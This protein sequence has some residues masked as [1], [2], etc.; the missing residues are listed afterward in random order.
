MT[1][2]LDDYRWLTSDAAQPW[3][4][5]AAESLAAGQSLTR[6]TA[7][8]RRD[9]SPMQTHLVLE[10]V[11]L[12]QRARDK[13]ARAG[14]MF[15]TPLGL[16]QATDEP[17]ARHKAQ[18]F[19]EDGC[20]ADLCC[21]IGGDLVALAERGWCQGIDRDPVAVHLASVNGAVCGLTKVT[22]SCRDAA[23]EAIQGCSA[24]HVDPDRRPAGRRTV[25]AERFDPSWETVEGLLACCAH[26]A[27]KVAPATELAADVARRCERQWI[28]TRGECRQQVAWFGDLAHH[29]GQCSATIVVG[30]RG[31]ATVTGALDEIPPAADEIGPF[32]Y[33]PSAAV[34]AAR[35]T[36]ALCRQTGLAALD[37]GRSYL[38]ADEP[39]DHPLVSGF[40]VLEAL[41]FDL[42]RLAAALRSHDVA[43]SEIKKRG[44]EID[45]AELRRKLKDCGTR[46]GVVLIGP[47]RGQTMAIIARRLASPA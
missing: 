5:R 14:E 7:R 42:R 40:E 24:W 1:G 45:P 39:I 46:P 33:E 36:A 2:A 6:L 25:S 17:L 3:L 43:P 26:G 34:R 38:T 4:T 28:E 32:V 41:P 23:A 21:G 8:L 47:F 13:F 18:R 16:A 44:V 10:Q 30:A 12:R 9:L 11:E 15:F 20:I 37:G 35:L 29:P 31:A 19:R 27:V 22:L